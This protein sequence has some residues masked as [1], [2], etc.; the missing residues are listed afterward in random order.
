MPRGGDKVFLGFGAFSD[1]GVDFTS[2]RRPV[3]RRISRPFRAARPIEPGLARPVRHGAALVRCPNF[4][5]G[6]EF[7]FYFV[8]Y[9]SRLPLIS[10]RTGTQAGIGNS[11]GALDRG[12]RDGPGSRRGPAARHRPSRIAANAGVN[13][14]ADAGGNLSVATA[15]RLR[16]DRAATRCSAAATSRRQATQPRDPRVRADGALLHRV[17]GRHQARSACRSTRSCSGTGIA[18]QGEVS[19]R[20]DVPLQFDDVELLFAALT[21]FEARGRLAR[22]ACRCPPTCTRAVPDDSRP[23]RPARRIRPR[24]RKCRAGAA[25]DAMAGASSRRPRLSPTCS[26]PR[27]WSMV[28]RGRP[29]ACRRTCPTSSPAA[30]TARPA[31]QRSR[32]LGQR[33]RLP[34]HC[35]TRRQRALQLKSSRR[36]DSLT[37]LPGATALAGRLDYL[38]PHRPLERARRASSGQQDVRAPRPDRAATSSKAATALTVG[39]ARESDEQSGTRVDMSYTKFRRR[40]P[41]QRPRTIAISS[42]RRSSTRSESEGR[43]QSMMK[44]KHILGPRAAGRGRRCVGD[45]VRRRLRTAGG[46]ARRRPHTARRRER[47]ATPPARFPRGLAASTRRPRR[48]SRDFKSGGHSPGSVRERQAALHDRPRR[49]CKQYAA[50]L[51]EGTRRCSRPTRAATS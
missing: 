48:A 47:P 12:H 27:R 3:H 45:R 41:L 23:L 13:A 1:Q 42:R 37:P 20:Q 9:H 33:Q 18:L 6:T 50:K 40:R 11:F 34:A 31:L 35:R 44:L 25:F 7:G 22:R 32:H 43:G 4:S 2:A 5:N 19:Y 26:A 14:A 39:V 10:G 46:A 16:D 38:G 15:T 21:P 36:I 51:T 49:T 29:H 30:R 28:A 8:N 24:T 17:S